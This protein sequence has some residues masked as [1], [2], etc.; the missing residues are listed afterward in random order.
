[1]QI[2]KIFTRIYLDASFQGVK[3]LF[4]L[5]F[6]NSDSVDKKGERNSRKKYFF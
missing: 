6:D 2:M 5:A 1:M 4:A 3:R